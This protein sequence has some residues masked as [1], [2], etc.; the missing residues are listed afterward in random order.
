MS[1]QNDEARNAVALRPASSFLIAGIFPRLKLAATG[2][3][4]PLGKPTSKLAHL[5]QL[6]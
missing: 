3:R 2:P 6:G 4:L 5:F 1:S